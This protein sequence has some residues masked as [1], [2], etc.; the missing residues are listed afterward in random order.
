MTPPHTRQRAPQERSLRTV[1]DIREAAGEIFDECG[2]AGATLKMIL[3]RTGGRVT[4]GGL[5]HHFESKEALAKDILEIQVPMSVLPPQPMKLQ[6][7]VDTSYFYV[8]LLL[9][10]PI[11]RAGARLAMDGSLPPGID[12]ADI[13]RTWSVHAAALLRQATELGEA[14][15]DL[16]VEAIGEILVGAYSG[17]QQTSKAF[18]GRKELPRRIALFWQLILPGISVPGLVQRI[19]FSP[20]RLGLL[21]PAETPKTVKKRRN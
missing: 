14:Q 21:F 2:Y 20:D 13:F 10:S 19:H 6:E 1:E 17:I 18:D 15:R 11:A 9:T 3:D 16:D 7:L 12:P 5:Y 4:K 8:H